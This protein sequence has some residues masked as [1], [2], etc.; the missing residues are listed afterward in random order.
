M[1]EPPEIWFANV[2]AGYLPVHLKGW[3]IQ[4]AF[5]AAIV[6]IVALSIFLGYGLRHPA[7]ALIGAPP[8]IVIALWFNRIA[9]GH[10]RPWR[11]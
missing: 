10:S 8:S 2:F 1:P 6:A 3:A 9:R 4:V 7:M 5:T 11:W